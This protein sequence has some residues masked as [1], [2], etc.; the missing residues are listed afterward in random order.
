VKFEQLV[1][2]DWAKMALALELQVV[3]VTEAT[4]RLR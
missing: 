1:E 4:Q 3:I 2:Q